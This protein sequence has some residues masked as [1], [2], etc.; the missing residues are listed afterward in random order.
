MS[1]L[2]LLFGARRVVTSNSKIK[3]P[4]NCVL[5]DQQFYKTK[6]DVN[7]IGPAKITHST[8]VSGSQ[9]ERLSGNSPSFTT[10][11]GSKGY[12]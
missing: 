11:T 2:L 9:T 8:K 7:D 12:D 6:I 1:M 4:I 5:A 10:K 3:L